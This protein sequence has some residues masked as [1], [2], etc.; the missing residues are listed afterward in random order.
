MK[1]RI[2]CFGDSNTWGASPFNGGG[3]YDENTRWPMRMQQILGENYTVIEEGMN[4]RTCV[5]DDP[6]EGGYKSGASYLPPCLMS[7]SPLDAVIF[8]LGT[9]DTKMRFGLNAMTI[10]EGMMQLIRLTR[11]YGFDT[12]AN[13][14]RIVLVGPA[15]IEET[16][17]QAGHAPC[18]GRQ[19][20]EVSRDLV[21]EYARIAKLMRC[22]FFDASS[23]A[24]VSPND[25]VHL[26]REGHLRLAEAMAQKVRSLFEPGGETR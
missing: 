25:G 22:D 13:P 18:F 3:R 10:G 17:L 2:L 20:I 21:R 1:R 8:M 15:P 4:G 12:A 26:S 11:L 14:P 6:I 23:I 16:M 5:Y 7:H 9:N 19:A 24:L